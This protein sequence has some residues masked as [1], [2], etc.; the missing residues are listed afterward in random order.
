MLLDVG[1]VSEERAL[2]CDTHVITRA[3]GGQRELYPDIAV[4]DIL[5]GD[6]MLLCT[7]GLYREVAPAE[8]THA[9][10]LDVQAAATALMKNCLAGE[11][12]DN[13]S[14]VVARAACDEPVAVQ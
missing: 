14:V 9:L 6:T 8:I 11:A 4:F 2:T 7:D 12:R 13:V 10:T 3:V 5:P 1:G